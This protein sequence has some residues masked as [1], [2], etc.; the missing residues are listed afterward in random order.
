MRNTIVS[1][2]TA[3]CLLAVSALPAA[4]DPVLQDAYAYPRLTLEESD[5][6]A[7]WPLEDKNSRAAGFVPSD[8]VDVQV[9]APKGVGDKVAIRGFMAVIKPGLAAMSNRRDGSN[10][11]LVDFRH[12]GVMNKS[13]ILNECSDQTFKCILQI[14]GTLAAAA[15][16]S[17][18]VVLIAE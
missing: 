3:A 6:P 8:V 16:G 11:I 12:A 9:A 15:D 17:D 7:N 18:S 5:F 13:N 4:A 10:A 14:R 1:G 2:V